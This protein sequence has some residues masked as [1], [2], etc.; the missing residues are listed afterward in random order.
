MLSL[1]VILIGVGCICLAL[2]NILTPTVHLPDAYKTSIAIES[3]EV[4]VKPMMINSGDD[5]GS[6]SIPVLKQK[7]AIIQGTGTDELDKG[8]G[9][10]IQSVMPGEDDNCVLSGHRDT[11][12]KNIGKLKIGDQLI[13]ETISG[14]FVYEVK[15]MRIVESDDKTVI[16]STK[17]AVLTLTTCYPFNY[18]GS[19]PKR[20]IVSADLVTLTDSAITILK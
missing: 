9:H 7:L 2:F 15:S 1:G 10:Y 20:Y 18:I 17:H 8:V 6:L 4:S 5:I 16:V 19:A 13:I 11:V 12:F 14:K 3:A